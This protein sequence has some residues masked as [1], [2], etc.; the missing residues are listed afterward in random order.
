MAQKSHYGAFNLR[1]AELKKTHQCSL[2]HYLQ[3]LGHRRKLD[4]HRQMNG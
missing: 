4:I 1:K 3:E 2:H